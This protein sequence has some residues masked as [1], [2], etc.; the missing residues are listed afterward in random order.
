MPQP[1]RTHFNLWLWCRVGLQDRDFLP[2]PR[3]THL[4]F[5]CSISWFRV[6]VQGRDRVGVYF[7]L[8][9]ELGAWLISSFLA[10]GGGLAY[11]YY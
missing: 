7:C 10:L 8:W 4:I 2:Q 5:W 11:M 6:G 3:R 9:L 1:S